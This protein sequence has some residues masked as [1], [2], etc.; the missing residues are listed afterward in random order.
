[1]GHKSPTDD[2]IR[3]LGHTCGLGFLPYPDFAK[4]TMEPLQ[5]P[6]TQKRSLVSALVEG[7]WQERY[8]RKRN[9][10]A[11]RTVGSRAPR[12]NPPGDTPSGK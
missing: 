12:N 3:G 5:R 2:S 11:T 10:D 7:G 4:A 9:A 1:M 6:L 8:G